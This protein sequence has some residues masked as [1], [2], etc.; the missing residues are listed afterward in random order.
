MAKVRRKK[1]SWNHSF[2]PNV[3][4]YKLYWALDDGISY[5]SDCVDVG[6]VT[7]VILPDGVDSF[8]LVDGEVDLGVTAVNEGGNESDIATLSTPFQFSAP[9]APTGLLV[10]TIDDFHVDIGPAEETGRFGEDLD[11]QKKWGS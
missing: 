4:G 6:Y 3:V 10:E 1:V 2:G 5:D 8:P 7:E 11:Q 9:K